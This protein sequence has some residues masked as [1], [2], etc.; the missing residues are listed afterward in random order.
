[1][2]GKP[3]NPNIREVNK[4][5]QFKPGQSGNPSGRP[6]AMSITRLVREEL[7]TPDEHE[8]TRTK[9][10]VVADKIV[11][12]AMSGDKVIAPLVWR[13][14][15]GDPKAAAD[16]S[17]RELVEQLAARMGL[18]PTALLAEFERDVKQSGAA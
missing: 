13:Y 5:T 11:A 4:A 15:D 12:M 9:G 8:P 18:D 3:G 6:K 1:M 17:L 7:L 10:D 14:M 16:L 2:P